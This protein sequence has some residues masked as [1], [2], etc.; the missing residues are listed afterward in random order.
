MDLRLP[1]HC[2]GSWDCHLSH[3]GVGKGK[4]SGKG[5]DSHEDSDKGKDSRKG[6]DSHKDSVKGKDSHKGKDSGKGEDYA[7]LVTPRKSH[8]DLAGDTKRKRVASPLS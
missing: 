6:N 4:D 5:N 7:M 1:D 3:H 2:D 8:P